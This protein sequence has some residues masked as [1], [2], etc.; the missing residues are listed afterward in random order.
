MIMVTYKLNSFRFREGVIDGLKYLTKKFYIFIVTNQA[1]I[2]KYILRIISLTHKEIN[3][4]FVKHGIYI[5]E[6]QFSP[7]HPALDPKYKNSRMK[8]RKQDD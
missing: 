1:G 7:Y 2:K 6:V 4:R 5:D 8:T 3:K